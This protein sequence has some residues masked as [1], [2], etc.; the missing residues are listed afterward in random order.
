[1]RDYDHSFDKLIEPCLRSVQKPPTHKDPQATIRDP[2][3]THVSRYASSGNL[4]PRAASIPSIQ[5]PIATSRTAYASQINHI[6]K[7]PIRGHDT[8]RRATNKELKRRGLGL[9]AE[10]AKRL[11]ED[12]KFQARARIAADYDTMSPRDIDNL[13][14]HHSVATN[15]TDP[16]L[17]GRLKVH[18][19]KKYGIEAPASRLDPVLLPGG[20]VSTLDNKGSREVLNK[21]P[22][23]PMVMNKPTLVTDKAET[24]GQAAKTVTPTMTE[25]HVGLEPIHGTLPGHNI[26]KACNDCRR[27][28]VCNIS[29]V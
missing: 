5:P 23:V 9:V 14:I 15:D 17:K 12:D 1:M 18:D 19:R 2:A 22:L 8:S 27:S 16:I 21:T 25:D 28:K 3:V 4:C 11:K 13:Y 6:A 7:N 24:I 26:H 10:L 29:M 20:P